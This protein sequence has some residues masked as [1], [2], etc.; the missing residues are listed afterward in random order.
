MRKNV[1]GLLEDVQIR[2]EQPEIF[3][4]GRFIPPF[5]KAIEALCEQMRAVLEK[6]DLPT[7]RYPV[8]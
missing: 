3:G 4:P 2:V 7:D 6:A 8:I 1:R 5:K